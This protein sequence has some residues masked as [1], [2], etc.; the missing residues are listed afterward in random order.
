MDH[1]IKDKNLRP[2]I[3]R[4]AKI[5]ALWSAKLDECEYFT[6]EEILSFNRSQIIEQAIFKR[7]KKTNRKKWLMH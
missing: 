6:G 7:L 4:E 2:D 1:N 5:P 3:N